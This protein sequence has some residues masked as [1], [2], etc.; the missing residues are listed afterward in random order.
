MQG[1][2]K[3]MQEEPFYGFAPIEIYEFFEKRLAVIAAAGIPKTHV[4]VDPG[5]G[6]GKTVKHNLQILNWLGLFHGLGVPIVFGASRKSTIAK[7]S[8]GESAMQRLPGSLVLAMAAFRQGV[9]II[10]VHDV[11]ETKQALAVEQAV[12]QYNT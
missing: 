10:R 9:Q 6:F 7:L 5:F 4:A 3:T 12:F 8:K 1:Q 11:A 2:P